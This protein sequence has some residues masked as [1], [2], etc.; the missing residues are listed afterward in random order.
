MKATAAILTLLAAAGPL[1]S[2]RYILNR[3][4]HHHHD[5]T[6]TTIPTGTAVPWPTGLRPTGTGNGALR[7]T[8]G[9]GDGDGG[10]GGAWVG[11]QQVRT[12]VSEPVYGRPGAP[13][14]GA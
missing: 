13:V 7:P 9:P 3:D 1:A 11:W 8:A 2:G 4:N 5:S 12:R 10:G 14:A 6:P